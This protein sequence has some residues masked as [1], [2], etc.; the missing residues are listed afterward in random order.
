VLRDRRLT[1]PK[2]VDELADAALGGA[3]AVHDAPA[4]GLGEDRECV[5]GHGKPSML[6]DVYACQA[7]FV[8]RPTQKYASAKLI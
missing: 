8:W 2:R 1:H 6:D 7:I 3:E 5:R 4:R